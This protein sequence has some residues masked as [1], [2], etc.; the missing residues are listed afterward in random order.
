MS[1]RL[2]SLETGAGFGTAHDPVHPDWNV[3]FAIHS[4]ERTRLRRGEAPVHDEG[5]G[6]RSQ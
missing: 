3:H 4:A 1:E 5:S 6:D 2:V